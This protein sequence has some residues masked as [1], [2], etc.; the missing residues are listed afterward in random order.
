MSELEKFQFCGRLFAAARQLGI[1]VREE[2]GG[3]KGYAIAFH[4]PVG[5]TIYGEAG[6]DRKE[7]AY[8]ACVALSN[9]FNIKEGHNNYAKT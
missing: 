1:G 6:A 8:N 9:Y 3:D 7:A 5:F 2:N 4:D